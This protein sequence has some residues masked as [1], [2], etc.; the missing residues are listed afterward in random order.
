LPRRTN[1][2]VVRAALWIDKP[3]EPDAATGG[4]TRSRMESAD[5]TRALKG[6]PPAGSPAAQKNEMMSRILNAA[7]MAAVAMTLTSMIVLTEPGFALGAP[8]EQV[9]TPQPAIA[10]SATA[11]PVNTLTE[12]PVATPEIQA[13]P[14]IEAPLAAP[15]P[16]VTAASL[17]E[18]VSQ[19]AIPDDMD[20]ELRCLASAVYFE[21]KGESLVGQLAVAHVVINRTESGRFPR[22][23]C[24]VVHQPSQFSFVRR[25]KMPPI[26]M[27]SKQW[28][29]AVAIAR[30]AQADAWKNQ[31][32]GALFFHARHVSPGWKRTRVA[33]IDNHIFYR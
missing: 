5:G 23:L 14:V 26:A 22:S 20:S 15:Q 27:N 1:A 28:R 6:P 4:W 17:A 19:T 29:N 21:S 31:A 13:E 25:G 12:T 11:V 3:V 32:P 9:A 2:K 7:S 8:A 33:Q 18:L 10:A 30:I 24:G 16:V